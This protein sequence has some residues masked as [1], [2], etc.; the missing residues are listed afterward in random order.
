MSHIEEFHYRIPGRSGNTRPGSHASSALGGGQDFAAHARL[1][2]W[3]D[4]RRLDLR[5][6]IRHVRREWLVRMSRQ[7]TSIPVE[8]IV[9]VSPSMH[10]G[11]DKTKLQLAADFVRSLGLSAFRAGDPVGMHAF[12]AQERTDLFVAAR[13]SRSCAES[14]TRMLAS[15]QAGTAGSAGLLACA[16]QLS[17]RRGLIFLVSDFLWPLDTL[18]AVL[19]LL[20]RSMLVPV[21]IRDRTEMEPPEQDGPAFVRDLESHQVRMIWMRPAL[22]ERWRE[23]TRRRQEAVEAVFVARG[24]QPFYLEGRFDGE[25]MS[26]YFIEGTA[27]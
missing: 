11:A 3:P 24:I 18:P 8:A 13:H 23:A 21:V 1:F 17:T 12:D 14:M 7:R 27:N 6:S 5:A 4:P 19:D 15:A 2:E 26:R 16:E 20:L 22:R 10:F 9:D 25:A